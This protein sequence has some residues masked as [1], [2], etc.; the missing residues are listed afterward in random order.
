MALDAALVLWMASGIRFV[1][2]ALLLALVNGKARH[3]ADRGERLGISARRAREL[4]FEIEARPG[5]A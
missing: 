4:R 2:A 3:F 1:A 5:E